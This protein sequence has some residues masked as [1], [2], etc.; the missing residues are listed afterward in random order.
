VDTQRLIIPFTHTFPWLPEAFSTQ[1]GT[2]VYKTIAS[3]TQGQASRRSK[4]AEVSQ[5]LIN[6]SIKHFNP[7]QL[8]PLS[9]IKPEFHRETIE[10]NNSSAILH[11]FVTYPTRH[12]FINRAHPPINLAKSF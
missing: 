12:F 5:Q 8:S 3:L 9:L 11:K 7:N 6:Y 1:K 10:P 2:R 4:T